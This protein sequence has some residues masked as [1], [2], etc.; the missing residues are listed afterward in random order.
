MVGGDITQQAQALE[1]MLNIFR[2]SAIE[3]ITSYN[4]V[5]GQVKDD[6][7]EDNMSGFQPITI[8]A[9]QMIVKESRSLLRL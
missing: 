9:E 7:G 2:N 8:R 3:T 6:I 1:E 5:I 4:T